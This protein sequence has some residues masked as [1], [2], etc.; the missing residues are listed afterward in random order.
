MPRTLKAGTSGRRLLLA[1]VHKPHKSQLYL[2]NAMNET[3]KVKKVKHA[4][5]SP[6]PDICIAWAL[7]AF[8]VCNFAEA[9]D[10]RCG[11]E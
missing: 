3:F 9:L 1:N 4:P 2:H 6:I 11:E 10:G 8:W 5:E 7:D